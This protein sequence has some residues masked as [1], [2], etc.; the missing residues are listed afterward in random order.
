MA[1]TFVE[2]PSEIRLILDDDDVASHRH[3]FLAVT[4]ALSALEL[5]AAH[6]GPITIVKVAKM[7]LRHHEMAIF[8]LKVE[9]S[10]LGTTWNLCLPVGAELQIFILGRSLHLEGPITHALAVGDTRVLHRV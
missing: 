4:H 7:L 2:S 5:A 6:S 10:W 9:V 3:G 8:L 1:C